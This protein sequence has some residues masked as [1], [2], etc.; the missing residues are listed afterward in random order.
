MEDENLRFHKGEKV[1]SHSISFKLTTVDYAKEHSNR[2][3]I[4]VIFEIFFLLSD[5]I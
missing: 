2:E 3:E 1:R 4:D 5:S